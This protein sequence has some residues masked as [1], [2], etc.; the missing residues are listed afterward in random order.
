VWFLLGIKKRRDVMIE[1]TIKC[2]KCGT[3]IKLTESLAGPLIESARR[4]FEV[5]LEDAK[6][7]IRIEEGQ[8][9][10][11]Q[12]G[13]DFAEENKK[14]KLLEE[15]I[16]RKD[17]KLAEAQREQASFL[18]QKRK[19]ADSQREIDLTIQ[20]EVAGKEE[21]IR[22]HAREDA[23][24]ESKLKVTERE[25]T[26]NSMMKEIENLRRKAEQGSQQ[27]QGEALEIEIEETLA[28]FFPFDKIEPV[29][30]GQLGGDILQRVHNPSGKLCGTILWESK[31]TKTWSDGW[32]SKLR[33]DQ[34]QAK[35]EVAILVTQVLP[36]GIGSF[37]F[38][39][40][41]W[42]TEPAVMIPLATL[43]RQKLIEVAGA[44][45]T[46]EGTQSKAEMVY[47]YMTGT[48]FRQRV[49][50]IVEAF[51]TM[52]G[53]LASERKAITKQWAK[54]ESQ[55]ERVMQGTIGMYGD[56]QGIAGKSMSE[57]KELEFKEE[58]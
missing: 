10:E 20:K 37:D 23:E 41:V 13:L 54:R 52:Q 39:E 22:F 29:P 47:H 4:R 3:E 14:R 24:K 38:K 57:I 30:K 35:A 50:A 34:R 31:R 9:A 6:S 5:N 55:I 25:E 42:V 45:H 56:L 12:V 48:Q 1:P 19:L 8:R 16:R 11:H 43:L 28:S 49:Q 7:A 18:E 32:L 26:I 33:E 17:T 36:K 51:T 21:A 46:A 15:E 2:P 58:K 27:A 40:R 44:Q 53:D